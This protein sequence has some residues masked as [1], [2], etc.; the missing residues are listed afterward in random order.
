MASEARRQARRWRAVA[1]LLT[2]A[3]LA[4]Q[5]PPAL[6]QAARSEPSEADK[7][8]ARKLMDQGRAKEGAGDKAGALDAYLAADRIMG[9]PTT[10]L[11]VA[12]AALEMGKLVEA[13]DVLLRVVRHP[14]S[15]SEPLPFAK[16][17][18]EAKAMAAELDKRIPSLT[19][20]VT[21]AAAG[22]VVTVTVDGVAVPAETLQFPRAVNPGKRQ[23]VASAP[24]YRS[25]RKSVTLAE[26][27]QATLS[28]ALEPGEQDSPSTGGLTLEGISPL[29]WVGLGVTVA[30]L[31]VGIPTGAL[32]M[33]KSSDLKGVC[34]DDYGCPRSRK[35]EI[36]SMT[37]LAHTSTVSFAVAGAGAVLGI[38][39]LAA[40]SDWGGE[41]PKAEPDGRT[42]TVSVLCGPGTLLVRGRF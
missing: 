32:A 19:L 12:E 10:G 25:A 24:G 23:V 38:V 15:P 28:L 41:A 11:S 5:A 4:T 27:E 42:P 31:G 35:S 22:T 14:V 39:G 18:L 7:D 29:F 30:G 2:A 8:A 36:D 26:G 21:G 34:D 40:L 33:S 9:V 16:A 37:A 6:A 20:S 17:R 3:W 1:A 13:R